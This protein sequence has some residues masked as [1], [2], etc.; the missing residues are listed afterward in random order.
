M[1]TLGRP[2]S[3]KDII[4]GDRIGEGQFGDVHTGILYPDVSLVYL[5]RV[6]SSPSIHLSLIYVCLCIFVWDIDSVI[7]SWCVYYTRDVWYI[8]IS[9]KCTLLSC[10]RT[11]MSFV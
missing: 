1:R 2:L 11:Y 10:M 6:I 8:Q 5:S 4:L 7:K 3:P 9:R